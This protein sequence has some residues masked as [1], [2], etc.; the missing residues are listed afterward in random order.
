MRAN[1]WQISASTY[2]QVTIVTKE[3]FKTS[4]KSF[5]LTTGDDWVCTPFTETVSASIC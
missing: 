2:L 5:R 4:Y 3:Y 1:K